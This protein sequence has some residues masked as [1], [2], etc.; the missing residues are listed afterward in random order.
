[1]CNKPLPPLLV[2]QH[3][4]IRRY[5][6]IPLILTT[7]YQIRSSISPETRKR[8]LKYR[9]RIS[10]SQS[11]LSK[12]IIFLRKEKDSRQKIFN[13]PATTETVPAFSVITP[14]QSLFQLLNKV[15]CYFNRYFQPLIIGRSAPRITI[16]KYFPGVGNDVRQHACRL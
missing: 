16:P 9:L 2:H 15:S 3:L 10:V 1:M 11:E 12:V 5:K 4:P 14:R 8:K 13:A 7:V 6:Q